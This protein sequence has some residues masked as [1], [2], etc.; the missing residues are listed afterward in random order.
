MI[1][2]KSSKLLVKQWNV[3]VV[4]SLVEVSSNW[5]SKPV[6]FDELLNMETTAI[7]SGLVGQTRLVESQLSGLLVNQEDVAM[8]TGA[9]KQMLCQ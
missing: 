8:E 6:F 9:W 5:S 7:I 1:S 3:I 4:F 2:L